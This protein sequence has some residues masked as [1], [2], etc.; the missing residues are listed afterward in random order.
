MTETE[1][2]EARYMESRLTDDELKKLQTKKVK[3][4][5]SKSMFAKKAKTQESFQ[6][7]A[8]ETSDKL[9]N[10]LA[11]AFDLGK[12]YRD[13]LED[14]TI[15]ENKKFLDESR[16][17]EI[18]GQLISYAIKVNIDEDEHEGMG[19]VALL[20]LMMKCVLKM[21]DRY[22]DIEYKYHMLE[23]NHIRLEEKFNRL[24]SQVKSDGNK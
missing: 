7:R 8:V 21:R 18:I 5:A 22:N 9:Q 13:L 11:E 15:P 1:Q 6:Q 3:L 4:D 23:K 24:S 14:K 2:V 20:T 17:K 10:H 16:E 19:S 12:Q